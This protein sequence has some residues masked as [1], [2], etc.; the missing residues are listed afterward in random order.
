MT[1]RSRKRTLQGKVL[2]N[3][4]QKTVVVEVER[5][6]PHPKYKKYR[7]ITKKFYAHDEKGEAR[8]GDWVEIEE[9]RPLSRLK[10]WVLKRILVRAKEGIPLD[11]R[12]GEVEL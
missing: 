8:P 10:R 11:Q 2:S 7:R 1:Q 3:R 5:L 6:A 9:S 4:M 12:I